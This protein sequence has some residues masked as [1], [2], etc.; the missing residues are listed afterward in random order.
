MFSASSQSARVRGWNELCARRRM[1]KP[2]DIRDRA[3]L[4]AV[5]SVAFCRT[6]ADRGYIL[7]RL[8]A[9]LVRAAGSV[10]ANLEEADDGQSKGDFISKNC[11]ALKESREARYWLR[12]ISVSE[13]TLTEKATP[14]IAEVNELV[15]IITAIVVKARSNPNRGK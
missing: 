14:L 3:F 11:I 10:G 2:Y 13:P 4:F 7:G 8:A 15:A 12:L 9:Q 1:P 6:V 5:D